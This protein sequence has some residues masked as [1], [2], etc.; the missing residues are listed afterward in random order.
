[1]ASITFDDVS[2]TLDGRQ[3]FG[4]ASLV[5]EERRIGVIGQNGAGKSSFLRL[6]AGL[7]KPDSGKVRLGDSD[8][9][10]DR[11]AALAGI[12]VIFQNPDHQILFPTVVE[13]IAF[14]LTQLGASKAE[15]HA[16]ALRVLETQDR[17]DWADRQC[18]TLSG[19]QRHYLCLMA[20]L[21]MEPDVI[22]LDE[23]YAG[24]DI[25]TS[26]RLHRQLHGLAQSLV[27]ITHDPEL[28]TD[29]DRVIWLDGGRVQ[30]DGAPAEVLP[31]F[32]AEMARRGA[33]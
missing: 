6:M 16:Q 27:M 28:L 32:K 2:L 17:A 21:A 30:A 1:M 29:Y 4:P 10:T 23:P 20:V 11:K 22:L 14:G 31:P 9:Y 12:G 24:L 7:V 13:E 3:V 18:Y 8:V 5:L 19:G 33:C 15:A 25:P 26:A